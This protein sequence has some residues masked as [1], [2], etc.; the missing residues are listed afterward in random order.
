MINVPLGCRSWSEKILSVS[1]MMWFWGAQCVRETPYMGY[2]HD[3]VWVG[4][5]VICGRGGC[6]NVPWSGGNCR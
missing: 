2:F 6:G 4:G 5:C 1:L 3:G